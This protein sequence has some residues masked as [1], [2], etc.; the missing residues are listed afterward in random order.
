MDHHRGGETTPASE[1]AITG[2]E[3]MEEMREQAIR[4]GAD[5]RMEDRRR[6]F[7]RR[8]RP[9]RSPSATRRFQA[10]TVILA[11]GAAAAL[12]RC[13]RANR[14]ASALVC[15][16]LRHLRRLLLPRRGPSR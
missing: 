15:E 10:R 7:A 6:G 8:P 16:H 12:P 2:P 5:L 4:F 14:N 1:R 11:M 3:L 13:A 9:R